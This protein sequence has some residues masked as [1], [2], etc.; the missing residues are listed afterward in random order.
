MLTFLINV[1]RSLRTNEN[2]PENPWGAGTLEWATPSPPPDYNFAHP[3]VVTDRFPLWVNEN[4]GPHSDDALQVLSPEEFPQDPTRRETPGTRLMD[5]SLE[6]KA[7]VASP[8]I[9]P[10]LTAVSVA[11]LVIGS[12]FALWIVP[13]AVPFVFGSIVGWLWPKKGEW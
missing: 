2:A 4:A 13:V 9:W 10:L 1:I 6:R 3:P 7:I 11:T 8:S 5:G 12:M